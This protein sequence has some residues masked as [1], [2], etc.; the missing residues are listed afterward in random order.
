MHADL[1]A[2]AHRT[3]AISLMG[4]VETARSVL[5]AGGIAVNVDLDYPSPLPAEIDTTLALI[6]R[7]C[8]TNMLRHSEA[9][10][11]LISGR[12]H[13][14]QISIAIANNGVT[15]A[16]PRSDSMIGGGITNLESRVAVYSG[17][18]TAGIGP[19]GWFRFKAAIPL[20]AAAGRRRSR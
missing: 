5:G 3:Q 13:G 15:G 1:R 6:M 14:G 7:E 8:V 17:E 10:T 12:H 20:E 19:D 16:A 9:D 18:V 11:C 2:V 4:D